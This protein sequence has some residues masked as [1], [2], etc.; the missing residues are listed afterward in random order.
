MIVAIHQ[1]D[2]IPWL[3]LYYKIAHSDKFVYLDD[4]QYSN[5]AD[6]NVNVIKTA[7]GPFRLKVP[8][9]QH[10][11]DRI[12]D[13]RTKDEL[14]WREKH[15][16]TIEM[17]YKK[18]AHFAEVFD[19]YSEVLTAGYPNIAELNMAI[20]RFLCD[21]FGIRT[22]MTRSSDM[23]ISTL[24][25]ERVIDICLAL[26]ADEYLSGN[27]A[28]AYQTESHFTDK[29]LKL[30]YLDYKPITYP[31]LWQKVG[32]APCMSV[33]DY[34]FNCGFDWETVEAKVAG[35]NREASV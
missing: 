1:P 18:A 22:P 7:N 12:I 20:N 3:G 25:E 33:L 13:V 5:E 19:G 32:F 10:L 35:I 34:V 24:R 27:G 26:G 14:G 11:G 31:Q 30:T 28:R 21:G 15:L 29:G 16:K 2:Y 17:N 23:D 4:A 6:H 8:V 9:E